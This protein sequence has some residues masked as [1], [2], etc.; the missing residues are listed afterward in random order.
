MKL[1]VI[2]NKKFEIVG[3]ETRELMLPHGIV[4]HI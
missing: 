1:N 4:D 3:I 2:S